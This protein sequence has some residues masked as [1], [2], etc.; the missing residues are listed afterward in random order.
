[1]KVA[2]NSNALGRLQK[3]MLGDMIRYGGGIWKSNWYTTTQM[4]ECLKSLVKRG[5]IVPV[6][7]WRN[8]DKCTAYR[9]VTE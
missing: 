6:T 5:L 2:D 3:K 4:R 8:G 9:M 7:E 1:M